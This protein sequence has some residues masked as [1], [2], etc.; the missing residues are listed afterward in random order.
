MN[1]KFKLIMGGVALSLLLAASFILLFYSINS[2][3]GCLG[4]CSDAGQGVTIFN[5][6]IMGAVV[7]CSIGLVY[8]M[9]LLNKSEQEEDAEPIVEGKA[10]ITDLPP[11]R[12]EKRGDEQEKRDL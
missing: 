4:L 3:H 11:P 10:D 12:I 6:I 7:L 9:A 2:T 8:T 5:L 1:D